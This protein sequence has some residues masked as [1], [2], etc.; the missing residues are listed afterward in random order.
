MLSEPEAQSQTPVRLD[1]LGLEAVKNKKRKL[2]TDAMS[3]VR[4]HGTTAPH[5]LRTYLIDILFCESVNRVLEGNNEFGLP[6]TQVI[7][8]GFWTIRK[9]GAFCI[10]FCKHAFSITGRSHLRDFMPVHLCRLLKFPVTVV[11]E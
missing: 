11:G 8:G 2:R 3:Q 1:S 4:H 6:D 10:R 9:H 7:P 5:E